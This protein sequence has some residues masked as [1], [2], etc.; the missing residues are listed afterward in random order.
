MIA[1]AHVAFLQQA[2]RNNWEQYLAS[3]QPASSVGWDLCILTANNERQADM[4]RR[5]LDWRASAGL[6]PARTR[7]MVMADPPGRRIGSGGATIRALR[8]LTEADAHALA[9]KRVLLIHSGGESKRLPH[10][11]IVGK[12]FARVPRTLPSERASTVFD[13]FLVSLSGLT[14]ELPAGVLVVSGDVLLVFDHLQLAFARGGVIGVAAAAPAEM[15][16]QHGVYAID[17]HGHQVRAYLHK[18]QPEE[19]ARW[20][21]LRADGTVLVDTGLVWLD[22]PT[23]CRLAALGQEEPVAALCALSPLAGHDSLGGLNL[24]GDILLPLAGSTRLETYLQDHSDGPAT[25]QVRA[26]REVLWGQLRGT[27]FTV[28]LL[29]PAVFAHVGTTHEYWQLMAF[30]A[31]LARTCGWARHVASSWR[32]PAAAADQ[33]VAINS[34]IQTSQRPDATRPALVI[35]SCLNG[36]LSWNGAALIHGVEAEGP[37][38]LGTD[39]VVDQVPVQDG[40]VS[41]VFGLDDDPKLP[42][43]DSRARFMGK[44]WTEWLAAAQMLPRALWPGL[45]EEECTLWNARLYPLAETRAE[46]LELSLPLQDPQSA[47]AGWRARWESRR[48]LSLAESF[49]EANIDRLLLA[50]AALEDRIAAQRFLVAIEAEKPAA[51]A[52]ALLGEETEGRGRRCRLVAERLEQGGPLLQI[53]GYQALAVALADSAWESRAFS[54]LSRLIATEGQV[55]NP[56]QAPGLILHSKRELL[57]VIPGQRARVR[58][59]A[60]IDLGG[61]WTDTPP[62]SIERGGAVLNAAIELG[63]ALPI[64]VEARWLNEPRLILESDDISATVE[65]SRLGEVLDYSNPSD[66]FALHKAALVMKAILPGEGDPTTPIADI[67]R[68][69]G[70]GLRLRTDTTI[71]RGSGLGTSSIMAGAALACLDQ[72]LGRGPAPEAQWFGD[73]LCLEQMMTTGG[74]WQD[75]VGGLVGGLKFTTSEPGLPQRLHIDAIRLPAETWAALQRRLL[76]VYT[77]Q[78]RMAKNLLRLVMGRWM[79]REPEMIRALEGIGQLASTMRQAL[80]RGDMERFGGLLAEHWELN[81]RMDPRCTNPFIDRL[82]AFMQPYSLGCKLAG[83]GGGGFAIVVTRTPDDAERLAAAI[84]LEY[85]GTPVRVWPFAIAAHAVAREIIPLAG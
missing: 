26:A 14:R 16:S 63:G 19:L 28:D 55:H 38:S 50:M 54:V 15:A 37:L 72:L 27:Q 24:Y 56:A 80:E 40:F 84:A 51:E 21:A 70:Y 18:P 42:W 10:C 34:L 67:L 9:E 3:L 69:V 13:E 32:P 20:Q 30:D 78:Q 22:A 46:S 44:P 41:R 53:R 85:R 81:K 60:R 7:F 29:Q 17:G 48:R 1:D 5:Q 45:P 25:P 43:T 57:P 23:A 62:Y 76:L 47:G 11:S 64:T 49:A 31:N 33:L 77:G 2:H 73:I 4:Y 8:A 59:A 79:A 71:P 52:S 35:D 39:V 82:I 83:A 58:A 36:P 12:L 66:P 61:G 74:G 65:P 75:Q 6:M 68:R